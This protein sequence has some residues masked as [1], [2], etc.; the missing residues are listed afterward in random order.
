MRGRDRPSRAV[1][2]L[3][4]APTAYIGHP[5]DVAIGLDKAWI[6]PH[7]NPIP[8]INVYLPDELAAA[9]RDAQ[10]P[11]SSI[12]QAALER[13]VRD[14]QAARST[15]ELPED[16]R[17]HGRLFRRFTPRA[18][19]A[20]AAAQR[21][22]EEYGHSQVGT[23]HLLLG[24]LDEGQN[25]AIKV[26]DRLDIESDDLRSE[27]VASV[28]PGGRATSVKGRFSP[29][30]K[31]ALERAAAEAATLGHNYIG[32]EHL[33]LGLIAV[34]NGLASGVLRR[35]GAELRTTRLAVTATLAES[36]GGSPPA[37]PTVSDR[38]EVLSEILR[39]LEVIEERLSG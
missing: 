27:L 37:P 18:R 7:Y 3:Q 1:T 28:R 39:R 5:V 6:Y 16:G 36:F 31:G 2:A 22:A 26:L 33:L 30:A 19:N 32:C 10:V 4:R 14:V 8:K 34:E 11:V 9:V 13:A 15:E 38:G 35:L 25:L 23:E 29:R 17:I 21:Q 20:V 24:I 12:C